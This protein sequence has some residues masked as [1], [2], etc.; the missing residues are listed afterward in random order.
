MT[1]P[2][3]DEETETGTVTVGSADR[4]QVWTIRAE[5]AIWTSGVAPTGPIE[6]T[7]QVRAHGGLAD[8][9]VTA[10]TGGELDVRLRD[11]L[12]GVA[13]G[14]AVVLYRR[15]PDGDVVLG[16]GTIAGTESH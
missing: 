12:T 11:P 1:D 8:A 7:V 6:C 13:R 16:S 3:A 15:D 10:T 2:F 5:R 14:Q 4:L 9:V